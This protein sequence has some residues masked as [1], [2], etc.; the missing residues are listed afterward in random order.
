[1]TRAHQTRI[2]NL[3][4]VLRAINRSPV[5]KAEDAD[6]EAGMSRVV[7]DP[8]AR[9]RRDHDDVVDRLSRAVDAVESATRGAHGPNAFRRAEAS[10]GF[11]LA[12]LEGEAEK[13]PK[14]AKGSDMY[15]LRRA[16]RARAANRCWPA[17]PA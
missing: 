8:N 1:M 3:R 12:V 10:T 15:A 16:L 6:T 17:V 2:N 13:L 14:I 7:G 4:L 5:T 11:Q 9:H